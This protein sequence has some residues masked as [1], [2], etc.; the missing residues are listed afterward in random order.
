MYGILPGSTHRKTSKTKLYVFISTKKNNT[1][2]LKGDF[3]CLYCS[4]CCK[5]DC[6]HLKN[7]WC[8]PTSNHLWNSA[9]HLFFKNTHLQ[10]LSTCTDNV[11]KQDETKLL[12][13]KKSQVATVFWGICS[14]R[15][16]LQ[17]S[18]LSAYQQSFLQISGRNWSWRANCKQNLSKM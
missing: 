16:L 4:S 12:N 1:E 9:S 7:G 8:V 15:F 14:I 13:S 5:T 2:V 3:V 10:N 6:F 11:E 17:S 18:T